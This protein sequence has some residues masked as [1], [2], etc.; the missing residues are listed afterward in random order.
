MSLR[1]DV[2]LVEAV[3]LE[4]GWHQVH[5]VSFDLDAY[6]FLS[7]GELVGNGDGSIV[8]YTGFA[9]LEEDGRQIAGP[10]SAIKAVRH[11]RDDD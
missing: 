9:F 6:E 7:E 8:P 4:D 3:L 2:D 10:L 11:R 5:D 1:I